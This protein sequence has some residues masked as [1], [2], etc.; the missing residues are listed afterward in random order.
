MKTVDIAVIGAGLTGLTAAHYLNKA[1]KNFVVF[2]KDKKHGGVI[3]THSEN[4]FLYEEGPNTG[5]LGTP[6]SAELFEDLSGLCQLETANNAVKKR[7]ILKNG[8]WNA[9]PSGPV[10]AISTPLFTLGDKF[11]ILG[12]PFRPRGTDPHET[13]AGFVKRR[14]GKS[15]L[16]YA[17]DPFILG[18]YAGNPSLLVPKYALPK[19]Y[20]LEQ[21]YGSL[22]KGAIKKK[23]EPKTE[24]D[25]KATREVFSVEGGLSVL[26]DALKKSAGDENFVLGVE[27][28]QVKPVDNGFEITGEVNGEK[29]E[30]KV[31]RII[32]T[33]GAHALPKLFPFIDNHKMKKISELEY[34]R[35]AAI[36]LGFNQWDGVPLN[37]FGGLIPHKEN[38]KIL[39][40]LYM[41]SL[42][43]NRAPKEGAL[44][45][46]FAGGVRRPDL[47]DLPEDE[48]KQLVEKEVTEL[49]KLKTFSPVLFKIHKYNYAIPQYYKDSGE[50][51]AT[52]EDIENQYPGLLIGGNLCDGI[53]MA[54]RIKQGKILADYINDN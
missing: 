15:F 34:A 8:E 47:I 38:R 27:N 18:V 14:M 50:R 29:I 22:I 4:G 30:Y 44:L 19:L 42:F 36:A 26:T 25:K 6:E 2:E 3:N 12:E 21:K 5:V 51:F 1:G 10:S 54:D 35:V 7:Y 31:G 11:R 16:D 39:G 24:R 41:S 20:N 46:I 17:I 45:T 37:G 28:L 52:I 43:D 48:I 53:G 13:L 49:M 33:V 23:K 9:L 32:S 40:V